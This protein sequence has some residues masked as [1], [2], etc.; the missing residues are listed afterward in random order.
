MSKLE[1][2]LLGHFDCLLPSG[3]PVTLPM[4]KA[5][6][7][8][9]Y[10]ALSPGIRHPRERL[11]NLLWSDRGEE[12]ARNSL[13][14][15][16]S[17]IKKSLGNAADLVLEVDRTTVR[18]IPGLVEVDALEFERLAADSEFESLSD[19][20]DLYRG[21]FLE[22]VSIRDA[23]AQEWL[24]SERARFKRQYVEILANLGHTQLVSRDFK[25]AIR[26]AERLVVQDPL[27]ES[28]WRL[29]M[30]AYHENGDRSHALQAY[31]RCQQVLRDELDIEPEIETLE[32]RKQIAG[33][34]GKPRT[35]T[36]AAA[37]KPSE[38]PAS[39]DHSIAVL[40]FDNL[41]GDPEQE[42]FSDGITDSI[43]LNL[44]LFP[45]LQVKSRNSSF[46]FKEQ[47]KSVGEICDELKV[48]YIVEGSIRR[49]QNRVRIT[50]Q[51]I[52]TASGNQIWGKRYDADLENLFD[53]EEELSRTVAATVT[54]RIDSD[55]QRIA[56]SKGAADQ[57][58][59]DLLLSGVY[60]AYRFNPSD[61][62]TAI[63]KLNQCLA[64]DPDNVR[65]HVYLSI[66]HVMDNIGR[67][68]TDHRASFDSGKLHIE[69]ALQLDPK[70]GLVQT[71]YAEYLAFCG[72]P[73]DALKHL[74]KALEINPND[75]DALTIYSYCLNLQGNFEDSLK[76]AEQVVSMDPYH[77]WAEWELAGGQYQTGRYETCLETIAGFRTDP[78][79]MRV[80]IVASHIKLGHNLDR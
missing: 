19:A 77:P 21:E 25:H 18:L 6:V 28:G 45:E 66:C 61:N 38:L 20:A 33:G 14:Q 29:L 74:G 44:S 55:L 54:S 17:A 52:D 63:E 79:F 16:L 3:E 47:I 13:R 50:V 59:Y 10:L 24:E 15:C 46:A 42:Y 22:G 11:I 65:A 48:D 36:T 80:F 68:N 1:L 60:H 78:S 73:A 51:L 31:K 23:S 67:W 30:H 64:Q 26:T 71:F 76:L 58:A 5:E 39:N 53:L 9:A 7:L 32:L 62:V 37:A 27:N 12:Q 56:I 34:A 57:Q 69:K 70:L 49:S 2:I 40:P 72:K 4:R 8:L 43:I 35:K 75:T 41:S